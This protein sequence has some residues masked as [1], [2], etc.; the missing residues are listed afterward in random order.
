VLKFVSEL[1]Q[2]GAWFS[3]GPPPSQKRHALD[4]GRVL[5]CNADCTCGIPFTWKLIIEIIQ[6]HIT[7]D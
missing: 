4:I 5:F 6:P 3:P 1:Q 2:F 7:D